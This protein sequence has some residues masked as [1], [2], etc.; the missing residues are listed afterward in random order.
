M[1]VHTIDDML[2]PYFFYMCENGRCGHWS[3]VGVRYA[4][5]CVCNCPLCGHVDAFDVYP[6]G[7]IV[8][9]NSIWGVGGL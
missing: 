2:S 1:K 3:F 5:K 4:A 6:D 7:T 9:D 8:K